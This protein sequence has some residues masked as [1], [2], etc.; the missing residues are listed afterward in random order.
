M[1]ISQFN[2]DEPAE[3]SP[4]DLLQA[5][6]KRLTKDDL[7][8]ALWASLNQVQGKHTAIMTAIGAEN[9]DQGWKMPKTSDVA[10]KVRGSF[11]AN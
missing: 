4:D 11:D 9:T 3:S 10:N 2:F 5:Y 1:D 7:I 8:D 6:L